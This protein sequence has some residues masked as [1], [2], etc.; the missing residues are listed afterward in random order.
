MPMYSILI[1]LQELIR[2]ED[3][4][5]KVNRLFIAYD[6]WNYFFLNR[7]VRINKCGLLETR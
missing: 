3:D 2:L 1:L 6:L 7:C 5:Y 4:C